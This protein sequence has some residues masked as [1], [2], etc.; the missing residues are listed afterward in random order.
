MKKKETVITGRETFANIKIN[1]G[2]LKINF[3][4]SFE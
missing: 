4:F 2:N 1:L 3:H